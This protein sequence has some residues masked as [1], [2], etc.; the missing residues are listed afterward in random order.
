MTDTMI[1]QNNDLS[2]WDT[3]YKVQ[4]SVYFHVTCSVYE[5]SHTNTM[6]P[7]R[8][9]VRKSLLIPPTSAIHWALLTAAKS[10]NMFHLFVYFVSHLFPYACN[11]IWQKVIKWVKCLIGVFKIA[12][13]RW[14]TFLCRKH[15]EW[16]I[17]TLLLGYY[18]RDLMILTLWMGNHFKWDGPKWGPL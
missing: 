12:L 5:T 18:F 1:S 11:I 2:S 7:A 6:L 17:H 13:L 4:K 10:C 3:L 15:F 14:D 16:D 9:K 8:Q